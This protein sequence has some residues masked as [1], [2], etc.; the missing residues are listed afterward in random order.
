MSKLK[1]ILAAEGLVKT[2]LDMDAL[3]NAVDA[4]SDGLADVMDHSA[5]QWG[6]TPG[7]A[8]AQSNIT[9][10][11]MAY[12]DELENFYSQEKARLE[13]ERAQEQAKAWFNQLEKEIP[14][15]M[16]AQLGRGWDVQKRRAGWRAE[17][18]DPSEFPEK[19]GRKLVAKVAKALAQFKKADL[20][21]DGAS[22]KD[23]TLEWPWL[24][25]TVDGNTDSNR[26]LDM[27]DVPDGSYL[28]GIQVGLH[29]WDSE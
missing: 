23:F 8:K 15:V 1:K 7:L 24:R 18:E 28:Y 21:K 14:A 22:G 27:W 26:D 25:A 29:L 13:E 16:K 5:L 12:Q 2:A 4:L 17:A 10:A 3:S 11:L 20:I 19:E 6:N 9:H